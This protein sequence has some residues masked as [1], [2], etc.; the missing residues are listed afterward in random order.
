[1]LSILGLLVVFASILGGFMLAGGNPALL[2]AWAEYI[3]I[4]GV[5][6][7]ALLASATP[8]TLRTIGSDIRHRL[9]G[10][11]FTRSFYVELLKLLYELSRIRQRDGTQQL[12]SHIE[13]PETSPVFARYPLLMAHPV[14]V[15][16]ISDAMRVI[17]LGTVQP[18]DLE[19]MLDSNIES[20]GAELQHSPT[21]IARVADA[22]PGIGIVAA[23][24]GIV[25]TMQ[26]ID[27]PAAEIGSHIAAALVG[28]FLGVL[29]AYGVVGPI[30]HR[31]ADSV[32]AEIRVMFVV[33]S[34]VMAFAKNHGPVIVAEFGRMAVESEVRPTFIEMDTEF[35][36]FRHTTSAS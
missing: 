13:R 35:R 28:T 10:N 36:A 29:L 6:L 26:H 5:G 18:H 30:G 23:V 16:F 1:M 4:L 20:L 15:G 24:L 7:G 33:K 2:L 34:A 17:L 9:R 21:T 19:S 14:V 27:G 32:N 12:E 31:I 8:H 3:V 25:V 11:L 22:F